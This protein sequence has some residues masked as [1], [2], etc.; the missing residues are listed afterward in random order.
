MTAFQYVKMSIPSCFD[1]Y[2]RLNISSCI[3]SSVMFFLFNS[4]LLFYFGN[5]LSFHEFGTINET[6]QSNFG[7]IKTKASQDYLFFFSPRYYISIHRTNSYNINHG[8]LC[9]LFF[10]WSKD[11]SKF[12]SRRRWKWKKNKYY[13]YITLR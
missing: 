4:V 9:I 3:C 6:W 13:M 2:S 8:I 10:Y 7:P 11:K 1:L 12:L 5:W